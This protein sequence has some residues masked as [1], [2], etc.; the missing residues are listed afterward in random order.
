MDAR[1]KDECHAGLTESITPIIVSNLVVGYLF[2]GHVFPYP[3]YEEGW[4]RIAGRC[5]DY[6]LSMDALENA[7]RM[8][9]LIPANYIASASH[10][11]QAVGS[12]LCMERLV[13]LRQQELPA[14]IDEYIQAHF[15]ENIDAVSIAAHFQIGKTKIYK[16]A[17][18]NYGVGIAEYIRNLRIEKARQLL[19]EQSDLPLAEIASMCGF[20]DYNYFITVFRK[21]EGMPPKTFQRI[22]LI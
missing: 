10:I 19:I 14:R 20:P 7:C 4:E 15:T 16:T 1:Y 5:R 9:P 6:G 21:K 3:T 17:K 8:Q 18:E 22:H 13:S 11:M 2:F 12:F